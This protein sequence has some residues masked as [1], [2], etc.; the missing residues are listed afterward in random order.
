MTS[1]TLMIQ[2]MHWHM[3]IWY[4][5]FSHDGFEIISNFKVQNETTATTATT[6]KAKTKR[7]LNRFRFCDFT[8]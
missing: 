8:G 5:I 6:T 1:K 3:F 7:R 4:S 2:E